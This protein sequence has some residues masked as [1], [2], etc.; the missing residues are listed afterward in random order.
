M[1]RIFFTI[2]SVILIL[3]CFTLPV[4]AELDLP[5]IF[6]WED[7]IAKDF[8]GETITD[9]WAYDPS[10]E[11]DKFIKL[12]EN[13]KIIE[14]KETLENNIKEQKGWIKAEAIV[15]DELKGYT[16]IIS[17]V[18]PQNYEFM[19]Y[20]INDYSAMQEVVAGT[21]RIDVAMI[22]GDYKGEYPSTFK[23]EITV[24]PNSTASVLTVDFTEKETTEEITE[25][26]TEITEPIEEENKINIL[27]I[28]VIG[29][30]VV[31]VGAGLFIF[32]KIKDNE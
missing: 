12:D 5:Q 3:F 1:K 22:A 19:L 24:Y 26:T 13:G 6:S 32:K 17:I 16:V 14:Q 21:Y 11:T 25:V 4:C 18:G 23:E 15:P 7:E 28:I 30:L 20:D 31:I 29:I 8:N 27:Q 9:C 10:Q 2:V